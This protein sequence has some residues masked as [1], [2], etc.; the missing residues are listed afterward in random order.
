[1]SSFMAYLHALLQTDLRAEHNVDVVV[2]HSS[3]MFFLL[4]PWAPK[5]RV[6]GVGTPHHQLHYDQT[7]S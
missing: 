2:K 5:N 6:A 4:E 7:A 3:F 1:M